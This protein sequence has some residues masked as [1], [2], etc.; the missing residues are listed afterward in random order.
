MSVLS[1]K[2]LTFTYLDLIT[3][4]ARDSFDVAAGSIGSK[5][6][7]R[8][9]LVANVQDRAGNLGA[10]T[11]DAADP[12][13]ITSSVVHIID[14]KKP[15]V[16]IAYPNPDSGWTRF[17]AATNSPTL[18][19]VAASSGALGTSTPALKPLKLSV[20]ETVT[21][22]IANFN[23][24]DDTLTA[25]AIGSTAT[26]VATDFSITTINGKKSDIKVTV[27]DSVGNSNSTTVKSV[28][29]DAVAP[30]LIRVFPKSDKLPVDAANGDKPTINLGTKN[31]V[32]VFNEDLD[33]LA[34]QYVQ[35]GANP[36]HSAKQSLSSS[37]ADLA[38][39]SSEVKITM[40]DTL[41]DGNQYTLQVFIR[42]LAGNLAIS[43]PD[44][45]SYTKAF[46]NPVAKTFEVVVA[47]ERVIAGQSN[48]VT[49]TAVDTTGTDRKSV[50]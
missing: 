42:D 36:P 22:A 1:L 16:T 48:E 12:A 45:M 7:Q 11:A 5:N 32:V 37:S 46:L 6:N 35:V 44:T 47:E 31:P 24:T 41:R 17:T 21:S 27:I 25:S 19:Q 33:S 38:K 49:L 13:P 14:D 50:V 2:T 26:G 28:T 8:V 29:H 23:K 18:S 43:A 39:D 9:I 40:I 15:T 3:G 10:A 30:G 4:S 20:N 34:V